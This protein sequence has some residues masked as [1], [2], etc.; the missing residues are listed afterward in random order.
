MKTLIATKNTEILEKVLVTIQ[1]ITSRA[2]S[3]HYA[4]LIID[5][6]VKKLKADYL[7]LKH[8]TVKAISFSTSAKTVNIDAAIDKEDP[9]KVGKAIHELVLSISKMLG[10]E[11]NTSYQNSNDTLDTTM[12][13]NCKA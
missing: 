6:Q 1:G 10:S 12:K 4:L 9:K 11:K 5:T 8:V 13:S 2:T 3:C 7:F